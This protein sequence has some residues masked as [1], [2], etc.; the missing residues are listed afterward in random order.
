LFFFFFL[1]L[2]FAVPMFG[3]G[4]V[5]VVLGVNVILL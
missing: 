2:A 3:P 5:V 1:K 4:V